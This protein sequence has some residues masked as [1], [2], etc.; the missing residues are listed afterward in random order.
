[1]VTI[2]NYQDGMNRFRYNKETGDIEHLNDY[3]QRSAGDKC[4]HNDGGYISISCGNVKLKAHRFAFYFMEGYLPEQVDHINGIK[5]D[6]RWINLRG[7]TRAE[8]NR[9][10]GV[11]SNN[12]SGY[13]GVRLQGY[14]KDKWVGQVGFNGKKYTKGG[15]TTPD[16]CNIW[17]TMKS[18]ELYGEFYNE[19][20]CKE[21][22]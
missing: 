7:C 4:G 13:R 1:M 14:Y 20:R 6:N 5:H 16:S 17:V 18:K 21:D 22:V 11:S 8:N 12:K 2:K 3:G 15:F 19:D 10:R 9:N